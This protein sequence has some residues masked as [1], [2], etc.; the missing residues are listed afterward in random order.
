MR[1]QE[2]PQVVCRTT[3]EVDMKTGQE[4]PQ[5][6]DKMIETGW[7][8]VA[9]LL[10]SKLSLVCEQTVAILVESTVAFVGN[11]KS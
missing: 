6:V 8:Q 2:V 10:Q 4:A 1:G 11:L 7:Q 3:Q 9:F 5:V